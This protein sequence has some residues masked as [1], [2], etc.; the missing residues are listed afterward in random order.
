MGPSLCQGWT[1]RDLTFP[2]AAQTQA[3]KRCLDG[4]RVRLKPP[5][6]QNV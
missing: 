1:V 2:A 5:T 4:Q 6:E 3:N